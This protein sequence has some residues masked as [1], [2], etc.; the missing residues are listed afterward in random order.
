MAGVLTMMPN[1]VLREGARRCTQGKGGRGP[2][3]PDVV[4]KV[5]ELTAGETQVAV[6]LAEGKSVRERGCTA[7][8]ITLGCSPSPSGTG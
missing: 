4:A 7:I 3:D 1:L 6:W 2:L 5:L 8:G